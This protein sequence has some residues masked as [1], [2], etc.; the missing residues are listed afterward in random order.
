MDFILY[1]TT[2]TNRPGLKLL[3]ALLIALD[4]DSFFLCLQGSDTEEIMRPG[5]VQL[6]AYNCVHNKRMADRV[7]PTST[8]N[9]QW[10]TSDSA[11]WHCVVTGSPRDRKALKGQ[12]TWAQPLGWPLS[13]Q[14]CWVVS[15]MFMGVS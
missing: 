15:E 11:L 2:S 8:V 1:Q 9:P 5:K 4:W 3:F 7:W 12:Q 13:H 6:A 14:V 10:Y